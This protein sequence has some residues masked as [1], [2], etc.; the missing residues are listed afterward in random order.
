LAT[1]ALERLGRSDAKCV[2]I[3]DLKE[4]Y[5]TI[6]IDPDSQYLTG[7]SAYTGSSQYQYTRLSMGMTVSGARFV[8]HLNKVINE[9]PDSQTF[10]TPIIDDLLLYSP[11]EETH[12]RDLETVLTKLEEHGLK[13]SPSKT[14]I[15]IKKATY[16]GYSL[17]YDSNDRLTLKIERSKVEAITNLPRPTSVRKVRSLLGM[18]QYL[19]K[20]IKDM[21]IHLV[22]LFKLTKKNEKFKWG[23]DQDTAFKAIKQIISTEPV[24]NL[25]V[26]NGIYIL[27]TDAS[28]KGIGGVLK[29]IQ[30]GE[31]K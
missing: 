4:A 9:I 19:S 25:P 16:M 18:L 2:S 23:P 31:E 11:D 22:P 10:V 17:E 29:Q 26:R 14:H 3:I 6:K 1:D 8:E 12:L 28:K 21:N 7:V 15:C 30:N 27:E 5:H 13:A 24:L 20:F